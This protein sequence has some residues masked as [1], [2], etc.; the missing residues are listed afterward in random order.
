MLKIS[1]EERDNSVRLILEGRLVGPWVQELERVCQEQH[2]HDSSSR[3]SVDICGVTGMDT[4]GQELL[5]ELY[6]QGAALTC[7]DVLN[8][9]L[10][11][12]MSHQ[13]RKVEGAC[14]P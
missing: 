14:R 7:S 11:E 9:Y 2:A 3:L 13:K 1:V 10:V 4:R 12:L 8:Q 5:R 6:L